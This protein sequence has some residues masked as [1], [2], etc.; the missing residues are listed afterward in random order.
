MQRRKKYSGIRWIP[1][2]QVVGPLE[3]LALQVAVDMGVRFE[4]E[5]G[6]GTAFQR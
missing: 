1:D 6:A 3:N 5:R 4:G 2:R